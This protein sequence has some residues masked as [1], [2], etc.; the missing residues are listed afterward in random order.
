MDQKNKVLEFLKE[1]TDHIVK[2]EKIIESDN[3]EN[4]SN[5]EQQYLITCDQNNKQNQNVYVG[6]QVEVIKE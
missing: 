1:E 2:E 6:K 4:D 5:D 3:E